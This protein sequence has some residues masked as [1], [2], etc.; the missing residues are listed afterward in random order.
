[1]SSFYDHGLRFGCTRCSRCCRHDEGYVF[2]SA[3]DIDRL[4]TRFDMDEDRFIAAYCKEVE[5]GPARRVSL[6]EQENHD[7]I[8]W[9]HGACSVYDSRPVQ[10]STYPFWEGNLVNE[11]QWSAESKECPGIGIGALRSKEEIEAALERRR[12]SPPVELPPSK[13]P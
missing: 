2:L 3:E 8:F 5:I 1:M 4:A 10:C 11:Q 13:K 9:R 12:T 6:R 7:C